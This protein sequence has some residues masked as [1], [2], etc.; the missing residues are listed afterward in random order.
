VV[1]SLSLR[2]REDQKPRQGFLMGE[3]REQYLMKVVT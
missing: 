2:E 1:F 3:G